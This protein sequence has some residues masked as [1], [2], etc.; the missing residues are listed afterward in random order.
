M[1]G[2]GTDGACRAGDGLGE[3]MIARGLGRRYG[4]KE[5]AGR[6]GGLWDLVVFV[7]W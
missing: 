1:C 6:F 3:G 7:L 5:R 4:H 2:V